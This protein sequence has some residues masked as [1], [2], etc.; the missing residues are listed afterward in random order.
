MAVTAARA[1]AWHVHSVG[2]NGRGAPMER[3]IRRENIK[4]FRKLV[5]EAKD[6]AERRRIQQLLIEEEQKESTAQTTSPST[7][8]RLNGSANGSP[9]ADDEAFGAPDQGRQA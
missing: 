3:F 7:A 9:D 8:P 5:L 1:L 6:D 4:R 2:A